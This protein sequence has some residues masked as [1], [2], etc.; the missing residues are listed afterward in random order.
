M[1]KT[2]KAACNCKHEFQDQQ[3]GKGV[4]VCTPVRSKNP[5]AQQEGRCTVCLRVHAI[6]SEIKQ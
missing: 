3:H 5:L 1:S 2:I 6:K 4:R